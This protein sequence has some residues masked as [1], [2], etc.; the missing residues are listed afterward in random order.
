MNPQR[1]SSFMVTRK[2]KSA[3][4]RFHNGMFVRYTGRQASHDSRRHMAMTPVVIGGT[5]T[6][7]HTVVDGAHAW[8]YLQELPGVRCHAD[9]FVP[10]PHQAEDHWQLAESPAQATAEA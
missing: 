4:V 7:A 2:A 5:Y 10:I 9:G 3:H 8:L 1:S 6:V